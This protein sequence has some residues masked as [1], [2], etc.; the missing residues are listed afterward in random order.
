M[1]ATD[2][3]LEIFVCLASVYYVFYV[4]LQSFMTC[5]LSVK[6]LSITYYFLFLINLQCAIRALPS[7]IF[8]PDLYCYATKVVVYIKMR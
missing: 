6:E 3:M 8:I 5:G 2:T 4:S 7:L 1:L